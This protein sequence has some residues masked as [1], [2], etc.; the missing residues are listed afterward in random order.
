MRPNDAAIRR[1]VSEGVD[2]SQLVALTRHEKAASIVLRHLDRV[3]GAGISDLRQLAT[4]FVMQMLRLEHL[5]HQTLDTLAQSGIEAMLL[6]GAGLAYTAY[7]SFADRPMGDLDVLIRPGHAQ[8][9]W[10]IMQAHGWTF[11]EE[12]RDHHYAG[13]Q[14]LPPLWHGSPTFRLEIHDAL[15]PGENPFRISSNELWSRAVRRTV[16]GRTVTTPYATHQL[17]HVCV[18]FAWSHEMQWGAWRALR[19]CAAIVQR[20]GFDWAEFTDLARESRAATCCFWT[21]RLARRLV[22]ADVPDTVLASLRPRYPEFIVERLERHFGSNLFPSRTRCPTLWLGRRLW[23]AGI[24]PRSSGHGAARPWHVGE[25]W[26]IGAESLEAKGPG[27]RDVA[28]S[29]ER[30]RACV[31]YLWRLDRF[32]LPVNAA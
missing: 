25:R 2:W 15:L 6:K 1:V 24:S 9:A 18:H 5:L 21:L 17:W 22:G 3:D 27:S 20:G 16:N 23:E 11:P 31:K 7:P 19:D 32:T 29:L 30:I 28:R 10:E 14:H 8:R 13:H 12:Y 4:M 26:G